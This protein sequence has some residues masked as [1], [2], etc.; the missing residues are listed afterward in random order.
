MN[1]LLFVALDWFLFL[2]VLMHLAA[3]AQGKAGN[4]LL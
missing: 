3:A 4:V 1:R 2:L